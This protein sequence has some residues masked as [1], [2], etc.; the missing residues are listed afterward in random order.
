MSCSVALGSN[1]PSKVMPYV[2][3]WIEDSLCRRHPCQSP[4]P[5]HT[6]Q[7]RSGMCSGSCMDRGVL[8]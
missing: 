4:S 5:A 6:L 2:R 7:L 1:M 8:Q 3:W